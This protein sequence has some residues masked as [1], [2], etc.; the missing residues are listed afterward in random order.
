MLIGAFIFFVLT[1]LLT[2][3]I[4]KGTNPTFMLIVKILLYF[5]FFAF[6]SLSLAYILNFAPLTPSE[7]NLPL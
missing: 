5:S 6:L 1:I 3:Y 2:I 7:S 4:Y